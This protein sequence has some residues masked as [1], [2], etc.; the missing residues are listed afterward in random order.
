M[1]SPTSTVV[2]S[3]SS[4][5]TAD[6]E[7]RKSK[8][9][10]TGCSDKT[11]QTE[12]R[13][14]RHR[15]GR[16]LREGVGLTTGLGWSDSED[17][18]SPGP[19]RRRLSRLLLRHVD[20]T[21]SDLAGANAE[22]FE[23]NSQSPPPRLL[24]PPPSVGERKQSLRKVSSSICVL[25][26]PEPGSDPPRSV[27]S[28]NP[29]LDAKVKALLA[30]AEAYKK[31]TQARMV[32]AMTPY[33]PSGLARRLSLTSN[34]TS[35]APTSGA[36]PSRPAS[37]PRSSILSLNAPIVSEVGDDS[38]LAAAEAAYRHSKEISASLRCALGAAPRSGKLTRTSSSV[39][40]RDSIYSTASSG[41]T[42]FGILAPSTKASHRT[43]S[44]TVSASNSTG[45]GPPPSAFYFPPA[46]APKQAV[47]I[48]TST[49][50][51]SSTISSIPTSS[52]SAS[53]APSSARQSL[54][55]DFRPPDDSDPASRIAKLSNASTTSVSSAAQSLTPSLFSVCSLNSADSSCTSDG[56]GI[57]LPIS[58]ACRNETVNVIPPSPMEV[59]EH[60]KVRA[61]SLRAPRKQL[62]RRSS[63]AP[64]AIAIGGPEDAPDEARSNSHKPRKPS[65]L[66]TPS[67]RSF[68]D[69]SEIMAHHSTRRVPT[70]PKSIPLSRLRASTAPSTA[71]T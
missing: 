15:D 62:S 47:S 38:E 28:A 18:D 30:R 61:P 17:E 51:L 39:G 5:D 58:P 31:E 64:L 14:R 1:L 45:S 54:M 50:A 3:L 24:Q 10:R 25:G 27:L 16:L 42:E 68:P 59:D 20:G 49:G 11:S 4:S 63:L 37:L 7:R 53:T 71:M 56:G 32:P 21:A 60:P 2:R 48:G 44:R 57:I 67:P 34:S 52:P 9:S 33:A 66:S 36:A 41:A 65:T 40:S 35:I 26:A 43:R 6:L 8:G 23:D 12:V 13:K 19:M 55:A 22:Y 69:S 70:I 29:S 46:I